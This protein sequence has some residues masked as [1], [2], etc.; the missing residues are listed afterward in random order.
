MNSQAVANTVWELSQLDMPPVGSLYYR[1][2]AAILWR[3]HRCRAWT[4]GSV[5][6]VL[7]A[8]LRSA[9]TSRSA[10]RWIGWIREEIVSVMT[11]PP[12]SVPTSRSFHPSRA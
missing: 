12:R 4:W 10:V 11:A 1:L 8:P 3:C 9:P 7:T 5:T 6:L 2:W